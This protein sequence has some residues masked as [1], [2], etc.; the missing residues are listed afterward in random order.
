MANATLSVSSFGR[1]VI[2]DCDGGLIGG[3]NAQS[4]DQTSEPRR[5]ERDHDHV[6]SWLP[7]TCSV[8]HRSSQADAAI[9]AWSLRK[10]P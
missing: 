3:S 10:K 8:L 7:I 4:N 6:S 5:W 1:H 9:S 2:L